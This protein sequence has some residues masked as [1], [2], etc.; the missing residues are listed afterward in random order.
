MPN[1]DNLNKHN[2]SERVRM[3]QNFTSRLLSTVVYVYIYIELS[4]RLILSSERCARNF[5]RNYI[6][7]ELTFQSQIGFFF[8]VKKR[9]KIVKDNLLYTNYI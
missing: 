7:F 9:S 4:V 1:T 5:V 3:G 2:T 8:A 6:V